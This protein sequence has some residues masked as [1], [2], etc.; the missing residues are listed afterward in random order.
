MRC[1]GRNYDFACFRDLDNGTR[2]VRLWEG[3]VD[4]SW[5]WLITEPPLD[6]PY[7]NLDGASAARDDADAVTQANKWAEENGFPESPWVCPDK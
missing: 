1:M 6:Y 3:R 2:R 4:N 7:L 5:S